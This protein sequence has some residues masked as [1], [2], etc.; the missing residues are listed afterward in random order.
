MKPMLRSPCYT[1]PR[2]RPMTRRTSPATFRIC[3]SSVS[4]GSR[5]SASSPSKFSSLD[6]QNIASIITT[7]RKLLR[8]QR[9]RRTQL[10]LRG[11]YAASDQDGP[12]SL[13]NTAMGSV[14]KPVIGSYDR[15][16]SPCLMGVQADRLPAK[17]H[18]AR[19]ANNS[20]AGY[21]TDSARRDDSSAI[22]LPNVGSVVRMLAVVRAGIINSNQNI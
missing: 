9:V 21:Y 8:R 17:A 19:R 13:I 15:Q 6:G 20:V 22:A 10:A 2:K 4:S 3:P 5:F 7:C 16:M 18:K 1:S 11:R 14:G 12:H